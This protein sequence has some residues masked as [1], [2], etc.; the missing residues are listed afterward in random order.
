ML[1]SQWSPVMFGEVAVVVTVTK[2]S[3]VRDNFF[4]VCST[5]M[6]RAGLLSSKEIHFN[7]SEHLYFIMCFSL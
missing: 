2:L 7:A 3:V 1:S 6:S 5:M 4:Y